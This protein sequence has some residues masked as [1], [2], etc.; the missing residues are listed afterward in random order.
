MR[1]ATIDVGSNTVRLLVAARDGARLTPVDEEWAYVALGE[2]VQA[3]GGISKPKLSEAASVVRA[4]ANRGRELGAEV[5]DV[6]VTDPGRESANA[7]ELVRLL[8]AAAAVPARVLSREEEARLAYRG[9]VA[10]AS[11]LPETVAVCDVGGYSTRVVVGTLSSGPVWLRSLSLGSLQ[12]ARRRFSDDPPSKRAVLAARA[13][14]AR[15][16]ERFAPPL[17]LAALATGGSAQALD[18][19]LGPV[20]GPHDLSDAAAELSRLGSHAV[21]RRF[22]LELPRARTLLAGTLILAELRRR[23]GVS[24]QIARGGLQEG[25]ALALLARLEAA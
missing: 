7:G 2:E 8:S 5:V 3:L 25:A 19:L 17:A 23:L 4:Y 18:R 10:S 9:A 16:F 1:V 15:P 13:E 14:V 20:L 12:L 11:E 21:A 22:D 24:L 6:I